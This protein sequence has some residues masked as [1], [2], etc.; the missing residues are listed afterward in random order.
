VVTSV[1]RRSVRRAAGPPQGEADAASS[2]TATLTRERG[3]DT[4][5]GALAEPAAAEETD[6]G[7]GTPHVPVKRKGSRRR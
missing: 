7:T 5:A 1:R 2:S 6:E 4:A 3:D